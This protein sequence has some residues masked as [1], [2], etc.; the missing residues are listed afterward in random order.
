MDKIA[1]DLSFLRG[2]FSEHI[3]NQEKFNADLVEWQKADRIATA[4]NTNDIAQAKGALRFATWLGG[5]GLGLSLYQLL[6][7][8]FL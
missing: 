1:D 5:G 8:L 2:A 4:A 7:T 6:K 3:K